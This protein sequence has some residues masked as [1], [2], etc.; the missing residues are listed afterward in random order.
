MSTPSFWGGLQHRVTTEPPLRSPRLRSPPPSLPPPGLLPPSDNKPDRMEDST[1]ESPQ[2]PPE[3][4]RRAWPFKGHYPP[5]KLNAA[6]K[7][8]AAQ[9]LD[10]EDDA[11]PPTFRMERVKEKVNPSDRGRDKIETSDLIELVISR[12]KAEKLLTESL[13]AEQLLLLYGEDAPWPGSTYIISEKDTSNVITFEDKKVI[14][15]EYNPGQSNQ[16]WV[17][18]AKDGWLGFTNDPGMSTVYMGYY[19]KSKLRCYQSHLL[20]Q[21]MFCVR[22]RPEGGFQMLMRDGEKLVPVGRDADK[23]LAVIKGWGT[24]AWWGFTKV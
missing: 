18:H 12:L 1:P 13:N 10:S 23:D 20:A 17:C 22:K 14:L 11:R 19:E 5:Q 2:G 6:Q 4:V 7:S 24:D 3:A 15:A 21:E 8:N 16:R 9:E